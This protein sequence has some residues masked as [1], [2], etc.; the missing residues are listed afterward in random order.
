MNKIVK[1]L[2]QPTSLSPTADHRRHISDGTCPAEV[3]SDALAS[4]AAGPAGGELRRSCLLRSRASHRSRPSARPSSPRQPT[5][6]RRRRRCR[7]IAS[8]QPHRHLHVANASHRSQPSERTPP[9]RYLRYIITLTPRRPS[10][11]KIIILSRPHNA[12]RHVAVLLR[13]R[14]VARH[15]VFHVPAADTPCM[16]PAPLNTPADGSV[17]RP[18]VID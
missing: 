17:E 15:V 3:L 8:R 9:L 2:S 14:S 5:D 12:A 13:P 4:R 1:V 18:I 7:V 10:M 6:S 11:P 16:T